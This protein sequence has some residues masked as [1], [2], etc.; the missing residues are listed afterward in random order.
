VAALNVADALT[1]QAQATPNAIAVIHGEH[2]CSYQAL[3]ASV[4]GL[5]HH[6]HD[7]GLGPGD[8]V[9]LHLGDPLLHLIG[10]LALARTGIISVVV[11]ATGIEARAS[12]NILARTNATAMIGDGPVQDWPVRTQ[13]RL[14]LDLVLA[15]A[16]EPTD[17]LRFTAPDCLLHYK[18]SSGTT[19]DPKIVGAT[20]A[21]MIA[22]IERE[23]A[24]IGYPPGER[25]LTP[26]SMRYD[27]PRRR[28]LACLAGGGTAVL[29]PQDDSTAALLETIDRHDV[30]H[31]SSVPGQAYALA[32]AVEP[33]RQ[34]FRQ[35]RCLR[36]SAGPSDAALH[37]LLRERL[38]SNVVVSFG[39]TELGP[40]TV[41]PPEIVAS[42]PQSVGRPMLGITLQI[43]DAEGRVLPAGAVGLIRVRARGMPAA[44]H[45]D[46]AATAQFFRDGWFYPGD[47]GKADGDGLVFHMGRADSMMVLNGINI[48]PAEIEQAMLSHPAVREA[49]AMPLKH[50]VANDVP[51]CAVV[52]HAEQRLSERELLQFAHARLG[53]HGPKRI[54]I[55]NAIARNEHG[56]VQRQSLTR[57]VATQLGIGGPRAPATATTPS[58]TGA[59]LGQL[60]VTAMIGFRVPQQAELTVL[61]AWLSGVLNLDIANPAEVD[62]AAVAQR[63]P[64]T[65]A[66][67]WLHRSLLLTRW[68]LLGGRVPVFDTPRIVACDTQP[69]LD[70]VWKARVAFARIDELPGAAY[71]LA[72]K[73]ALRLCAWV[74]VHRIDTKN[75]Q[76][77]YA[78][79]EAR[80]ISKLLKMFDAGKSTLPLLAAAYHKSIPFVHLG[81]GVFQLGW[82]VRGQRIARSVT[83]RDSAL[84]ARLC[85]DKAL[86]AALLRKAG[87]PAPVHWVVNSAAAAKQAALHLGWPVVV[88]P[89]DCERGEGVVVDVFDE[90]RLVEAF[91]P[92]RARSR[93]K[94][95]L[96]ERQVD[97]VCHRLFIANGRLLYAVKRLPM[98][99]ECDGYGTIASLVTKELERQARLPPWERSGI[100]PLDGAARAAM[101]RAGHDETSVPPKGTLVALRRIE[102]TDMGGVDE[103]VTQRVHPDNLAVALAAAE[104]FGLGMAGVDIISADIAR[105]WYEN[106]AIVNEVNF[107]PLLGGGEI[108]RRHIPAFLDD[109]MGGPATIA[110]EVFVGG[111]AAWAVA[112]Q[113]WREMN[114]DGQ[115]AF[116]SGAQRTLEPS[117]KEWRMSLP[118]LYARTRALV[119]CSRVAALVLA[120]Q[121][122]EWLTTGLPLEAV[123]QVTVVDEDLSSWPVLHGSVSRQSTEALL[124]QLR[125][126][127]RLPTL[128]GLG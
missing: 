37:R 65:L 95:V 5:C 121:S 107:A 117:G 112:E 98:S 53:S 14:D 43:A 42:H 91:E 26:V 45:D 108:S 114:Q 78:L 127:K 115:A 17:G 34:R 66:R 16:A 60:S 109:F 124:R 63:E 59:V 97:G 23:L 51:V 1:L 99:I 84:G 122:D 10:I 82:G 58:G 8:V 40:L 41:A 75:L 13:I 46:P 55:L 101:A 77:F 28:Y 25:Y 47:L 61:D 72:L 70:G 111:D 74:L 86:T 104:L 57:A 35:M 83:G 54:A 102:S 110:V 27:G 92:A 19:G 105:P 118:G 113:R 100:R 123:S 85:A 94:A 24:S 76:D 15:L 4:W 96:V 33:G 39:C 64:A 81:G 119:L 18:T 21:G 93:A 89:L 3:E 22:S 12:A 2:S 48:Y 106:G 87:L 44:Y 128:A 29:P 7:K 126:W 62:S 38:C 32:A 20:H 120:V 11:A 31:F 79:A 9:G 125:R 30:R 103:E 50:L 88:K 52:L 73:G 56:K 71:D 69:G 116:L 90:T 67:S 49:V 68:L 6:F 80:V 36:L